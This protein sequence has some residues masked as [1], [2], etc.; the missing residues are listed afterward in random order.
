MKLRHGAAAERHNVRWKDMKHISRMLLT[1]FAFCLANPY[2]LRAQTGH[3]TGTVTEASGR[4]I[5]Y[6]NVILIG[7]N[8]GGMAMKNG[9]YVIPRVPVGRH[10]LKAVMWGYFPVEKHDIVVRPGATT[11]VDFIFKIAPQDT[12]IVFSQSAIRGYEAGDIPVPMSSRHL[13]MESGGLTEMRLDQRREYPDTLRPVQAL[14]LV[15]QARYELAGERD[16]TIVRILVEGSNRGQNTVDLCGVFSY[17]E[18]PYQL[19]PEVLMRYLRFGRKWDYPGP[20]LKI[21]SRIHR[22]PTLVCES[23]TLVPGSRV[24]D[25]LVFSYQTEEYRKWPGEVRLW[26]LFFF[27]HGGDAW[28]D[29]QYVDLGVITVPIN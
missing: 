15:F 16:S 23:T 8:L 1:A 14:G 21:G 17:L 19:A 10:T 20:T 3:I 28:E 18:L 4:P 5:A 22:T 13:E 9:T 29:T 24:S 12:A 6:A 7:T 26:C 25:A 27:G 2:A 11:E